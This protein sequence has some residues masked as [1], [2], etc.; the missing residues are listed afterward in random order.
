M[1]PSPNTQDL[2]SADI[3]LLGDILGQV[4]RRQAGLETFEQEELVRALAKVRRQ[5]PNPAID[6]RLNRLIAGLSL[7]Q[8]ELIARA[9]NTYFELV[10]LAEENHR[11]RVLRRLR[12]LPNPESPDAEP[13]WQA[14][15][16]TI[17]GIAV[18][19]KNTG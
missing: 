18:G 3:H 8:A 10:N 7:D 12:A 9:F 14:I 19:L 2:L 17:N 1:L 15:F 11:V 6:D 5:D 4:I 16:M 13:I